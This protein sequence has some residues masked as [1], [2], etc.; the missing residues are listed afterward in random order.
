MAIKSDAAYDG[1]KELKE[2]WPIT[3]GLILG[4]TKIDKRQTNLTAQGFQYKNEL[5]KSSVASRNKEM[6]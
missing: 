5:R 6:L 2:N 4:T 3:E 1:D